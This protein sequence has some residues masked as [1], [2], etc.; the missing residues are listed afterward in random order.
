[1]KKESKAGMTLN[2]SLKAGRTFNTN[3]GYFTAFCQ[4][5]ILM[6][7]SSC[8]FT[9]VHYVT[10]V[11]EVYSLLSQSLDSFPVAQTEEFGRTRAANAA[12]KGGSAKVAQ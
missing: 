8:V 12:W 5:P 2:Q 7:S 9:S 3:F 6:T 1:M 4:K 10:F 11:V